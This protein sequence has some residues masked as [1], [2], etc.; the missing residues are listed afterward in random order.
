MFAAI[1]TGYGVMQAVVQFGGILAQSWQTAALFTP[2]CEA[3]TVYELAAA[4]SL[5]LSLLQ[6]ACTVQILEHARKRSWAS[7]VGVYA[8]RLA[9][10]AASLA[11]SNTSSTDSCIASIPVQ[12]V[13]VL[14]LVAWTAYLVRFTAPPSPLRPYATRRHIHRYC[15]HPTAGWWRRVAGPERRQR[16]GSG[17]PLTKSGARHARQQAAVRAERHGKS[18]AVQSLCS[19]VEGYGSG[20]DGS[21]TPGSGRGRLGAPAAGADRGHRTSQLSGIKKR[22]TRQV[23]TGR[24]CV[25]VCV[26][27]EQCMCII[28]AR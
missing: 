14:A 1:G 12:A 18:S 27:S 19:V 15:L 9:F 26:S 28:L 4:Q 23:T 16:G 20:G 11:N 24:A 22:G 7:L 25:R 10:S 21:T 13:V 8:L 6:M 17:P 5:L 3:L 2:G